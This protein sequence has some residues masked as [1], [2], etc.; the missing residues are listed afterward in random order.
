[1]QLGLEVINTCKV[2]HIKEVRRNIRQTLID[3]GVR[4]EMKAATE[5]QQRSLM[6][7]LGLEVRADTARSSYARLSVLCHHELKPIAHKELLMLQRCQHGYS[8]VNVSGT[9]ARCS[10]PHQMNVIR[11]REVCCEFCSAF[12][13]FFL[14]ATTCAIFLECCPVRPGHRF[15]LSCTWASARHVPIN[16]PARL[17]R[18]MLPQ[19]FS[20][21]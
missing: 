9:K 6:I 16:R 14:L 11:S 8:L 18:G 5:A 12:F 2:D 21:C 10:Q 4:D 20:M 3:K 17:L 13:V 7:S 15:P 19:L 1:M